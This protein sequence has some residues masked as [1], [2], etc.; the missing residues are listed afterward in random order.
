[1]RPLLTLP[2]ALHLSPDAPDVLSHEIPRDR[3]IVLYCTWPS[4]ATTA[5]TAMAIHKVGIPRVCPL[6]SGYDK[7]NSLRFPLDQLT[8]GKLTKL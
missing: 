3:D 7:W 1:M 8:P 2:G 4:E 6:R 5:K